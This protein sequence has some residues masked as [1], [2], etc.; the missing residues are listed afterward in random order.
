MFTSSTSYKVLSQSDEA[1]NERFS[2]S[3]SSG[4]LTSSQDSLALFRIGNKAPKLTRKTRRKTKM[5]GI[6]SFDGGESYQVRN[7]NR[8]K[9]SEVQ[10]IFSPPRERLYTHEE[11]KAWLRRLK[12]ILT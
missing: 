7:F 6:S 1:E 8:D 2:L 3:A 10:P 9:I 11:E 4:E 12:A 5:G